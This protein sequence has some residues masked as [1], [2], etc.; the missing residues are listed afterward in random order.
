MKKP[1]SPAAD[2]PQS[3]M[4]L[5]V[6]I[7]YFSEKGR[8]MSSG[9]KI[10][11]VT[12]LRKDLDSLK[13]PYPPSGNVWIDEASHSVYF[14]WTKE[15]NLKTLQT[16]FSTVIRTQESD[17][18]LKEAKKSC[19]IESLSV[20]EGSYPS[21]V[22]RPL[23]PKTLNQ[24][25]MKSLE[26]STSFMQPQLRR[27]QSSPE[28]QS[29][30]TPSV[31]S[32]SSL[33]E[34][35]DNVVYRQ[36]P[37]LPRAMRQ[38]STEGLPSSTSSHPPPGSLDISRS[39]ANSKETHSPVNSSMVPPEPLNKPPPIPHNSSPTENDKVT[40]G[41]SHNEPTSSNNSPKRPLPR[42]SPP[43]EKRPKHD[44]P[45]L[46]NPIPSSSTS[47]PLV[48]SNPNSGLITS[49]SREFWDNRRSMTALASKALVLEAKMR[50]LNA[51][52]RGEQRYLYSD[53]QEIEERLVRV[54]KMFEEERQRREQ[55]EWL[56][57]SIQQECD[58][59][60]I[61]PSLL[62]AFDISLVKGN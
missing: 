13:L 30:S 24:S 31:K 16:R 34:Q 7:K 21:S 5:V 41:Y 3:T 38:R 53:M 36:P 10:D 25:G 28:S 6:C 35:A 61:V 42:T 49:L 37:T 2:S 22:P 23:P 40:A 12:N 50:D 19:Y 27:G 55:M 56:M 58:N 59:P 44:H 11:V 1:P 48:K 52:D 45:D 17:S 47:V 14:S 20:V 46:P 51:E 39:S 29:S 9:T 8:W 54:E 62:A 32:R 15:K 33:Q 26:P 60:V 4:G 43:Q 18:W 57:K